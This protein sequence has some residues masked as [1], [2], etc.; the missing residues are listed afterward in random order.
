M[1]KASIS[2]SHFYHHCRI[3]PC[4]M[5]QDSFSTV[6][7]SY[8]ASAYITARLISSDWLGEI[9]FSPSAETV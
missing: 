1:T 4:I 5:I 2:L 6:F 9:E 7:D 3:I 8:N